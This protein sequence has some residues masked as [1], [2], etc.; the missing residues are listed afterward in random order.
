LT[1]ITTL[2]KVIA[3]EEAAQEENEM[4]SEDSS[5]DPQPDPDPGSE[6]GPTDKSTS[7]TEPEPIINDAAG[8]QEGNFKIDPSDD[9]V[10]WM[11]MTSF[12]L[13]G[14]GAA[15]FVV[16]AVFGGRLISAKK[17]FDAAGYEPGRVQIREDMRRYALICDITFIA[18]GALVV[19]GGALFFVDRKKKKS[20]NE[21]PVG[22]RP[23][24]FR[25]TDG[26]VTLIPT[27]GVGH[28][29]LTGGLIGRF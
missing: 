5:N 18:G 27:F 4:Q 13:L 1:A 3:E 15:A 26:A 16:G 29:S 14:G 24:E 22:K 20:K 7:G 12:S 9:D 17:D 11:K 2:K 6:S 10:G 28:G 21:T 25:N 19:A 8:P 23:G